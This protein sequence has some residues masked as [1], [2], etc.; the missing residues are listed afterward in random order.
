MALTETTDIDKIEVL[1]DA[2]VIQVRQAT[3][4]YRDGVEIT[5]IAAQR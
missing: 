4:I 2:K 3:C 1:L 5:A